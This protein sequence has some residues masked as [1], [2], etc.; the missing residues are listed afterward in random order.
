MKPW[1]GQAVG[2]RNLGRWLNSSARGVASR[3]A[4]G[5]RRRPEV[6]TR[7]SASLIRCGPPLIRSAALLATLTATHTGQT[8][9]PGRPAPVQLAAPPLRRAALG[10]RPGHCGDHL[11]PRG[12]PGPMP[13][14][15]RTAPAP[16]PRRGCGSAPPCDARP[17]GADGQ[18]TRGTAG[19][20]G[21]G[22]CT[23]G[24]APIAAMRA[25]FR[26]SS[27]SVLRS[28]FLQPRA[29]W[30]VLATVN[31]RP[32]SRQRSASHPQRCGPRRRRDRLRRRPQGVGRCEDSGVGRLLCLGVVDAGD[33]LELAEADA[34]D[35]AHGRGAP[36]G[37]GGGT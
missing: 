29:S 35:S 13:R 11:Q 20:R 22:T 2:G 14:R 36:R 1:A 18:P 10:Q 9:L 7:G 31:S 30:L 8:T 21:S 12:G 32:S 15:P 23:P 26:A 19:P 17:A 6:S 34:E 16:G 33:A 3:I 37:G 27:R 28:S 25:R 4:V 24:S 5:C